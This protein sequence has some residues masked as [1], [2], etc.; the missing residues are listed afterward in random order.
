V[1]TKVLLDKTEKYRF[2][3]EVPLDDVSFQG[4]WTNNGNDALAGA[5]AAIE[6]RFQAKDV[7]LVLGGRGTVTEMLEG[8]L[9]GKFKVEGYPRLYPIIKGTRLTTGLL[10]LDMTPS[11]SAYDFTFG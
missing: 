7:Y 11:I 6:L 3:P 8:R 1:G 10:Q 9:I 5:G 4:V 2:G